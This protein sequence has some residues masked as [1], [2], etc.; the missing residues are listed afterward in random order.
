MSKL[1]TVGEV[2]KLLK[3]HPVTVYR[4][5]K[6]NKIPH[7]RINDNGL[8]FDEEE[9]ESWLS[10]R[11]SKPA[12]DMGSKIPTLPV[13]LTGMPPNG[14]RVPIVGGTSE[15]PKGKY[16]SRLNYGFGAIYVRISSS[17][18]PRY[19]LDYFEKGKRVQ[20]VCKK[21]SG[22][23][24]AYHELRRAVFKESEKKQVSF[25]E[26]AA[27]YLEGY[28]KPTKKSWKTDAARLT[29]LKKQF[30][31]ADLRQITP[32]Q[33][34]RFRG[35][36]LSDGV[37]RSTTNR[38][39]ALLKRM[40]NI[41]IDEGYLESNPARKIRMFSEADYMKQRV[42]TT[43]EENKLI[44]TC[45]PHTKDI[46][47]FALNTGMRLGEILNLKWANVDQEAGMI[48]VEY[49]KSG[50][51]RYI[52]MNQTLK[53]LLLELRKERQEY[54]FTN[55]DSKDRFRDIKRSFY[56]GCRRAGITGLR[57]HDL[58]HTFASRL[59]RN[60]VDIGTVRKLLGHSTLLVTQRYVH[61]D[62][63]SMRMAVGSLAKKD[64][65]LHICDTES[66]GP[67][68]SKIEASVN[69]SISVN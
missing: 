39:V 13:P 29:L 51:T 48:K 63:E 49:T 43:D 34:E 25:G 24:D 35:S 42:L 32:M 20:R 21:A 53:G 28:A 64:N 27:E 56:S 2:S 26:F 17:G 54:V 8:R 59:V 37:K 41:A 12:V 67:L 22:P 11:S 68:E 44:E 52:P 45:F 57:F 3:L 15:M 66:L 65:L 14:R 4:Y 50:K 10:R 55:P 7:I 61:T 60:G 30:K 19:Y 62:E 36:L 1:L 58:R 23:E 46:V 33:I 38:Y 5:V 40:L 18:N 6:H 69:E 47:V 31:D 16:K 9:I